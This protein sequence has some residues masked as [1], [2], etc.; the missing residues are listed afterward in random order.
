VLLLSV[1]MAV[2]ALTAHS[3][4][5]SRFNRARYN[6][7]QLVSEFSTRLKDTVELDAVGAQLAGVGQKAL[8]PAHV[9]LWIS[10]GAR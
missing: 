1:V 2:Q 5:R 9:S 10:G 4:H 3:G 8:E 7:D 6:A